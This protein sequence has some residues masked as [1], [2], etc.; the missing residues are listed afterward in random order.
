[1]LAPILWHFLHL[2]Q[3]QRILTFLSPERDPLGAGYHIIQSKIAVGSGG[4]WGKGWLAGTQSHLNFIPEHATDFIFAVIG[5][6]FG[7]F[8]GLLLIILNLAIVARCLY[9]ASV[10]QE[11]YTRLLSGSIG[12]MFFLSVFINIGMVT[13]LMPVVGLPLP[14]VSYGGTSLITL[15]ASFGI[16]MSIS[17]HRKIL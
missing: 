11:T 10:A 14:M 2:Y 5:E 8:G 1:L 9:I 16:V 17:G 12:L 7:F 15:F 3:Q 4:F 6:E 13:G